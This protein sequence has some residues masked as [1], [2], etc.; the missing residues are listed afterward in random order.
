MTREFT[1][2]CTP[3]PLVFGV[4]AALH[5]EPFALRCVSMRGRASLQ[6]HNA[7]AGTA[8]EGVAR[9]ANKDRFRFCR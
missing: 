4:G 6:A 9:Q 1:V 2:S 5:R 8:Q 7:N 3:H